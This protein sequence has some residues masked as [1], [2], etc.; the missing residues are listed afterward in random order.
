VVDVHRRHT[1][2]RHRGGKHVRVF[3]IEEKRRVRHLVGVLI[4]RPPLEAHQAIRI[5]HRKRLQR[6]HVEQAE[7]RHVHAHPDGQHQRRDQSKSR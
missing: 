4:R 1:Q 2:H 5:R 7:G 6:D 3:L